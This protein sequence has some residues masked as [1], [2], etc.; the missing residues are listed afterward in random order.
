M[1]DFEGILPGEVPIHGVM[2]IPTGALFGQGCLS[3][4][5]EDHIRGT[6]C[7]IMM[8]IEAPIFSDLGIVT[9]LAWKTGRPGPV[10]TGREHQSH[11]GAVITWLKDQL[12]LCRS[13]ESE[14]LAKRANPGGSY[15]SGSGIFRAGSTVLAQ[16]LSAAFYKY[17]PDHRPGRI[18]KKRDSA[19]LPIRSRILWN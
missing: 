17:E 2:G 18:S 15:L 4:D 9:S 13:G 5:D 3:K 14:A 19:A 10:R 16:R 11:T 12:G 6:G 8:K 7:S 1:T